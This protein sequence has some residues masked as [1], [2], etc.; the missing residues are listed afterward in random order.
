M[1]P[2]PAIDGATAETVAQGL[3]IGFIYLSALAVAAAALVTAAL[4]IS[5]Y[6]GLALDGVEHLAPRGRGARFGS[7]LIASLGGT[8]LLCLLAAAAAYPLTTREVP[9]TLRTVTAKVVDRDLDPTHEAIAEDTALAPAVTTGGVGFAVVPVERTV[10]VPSRTSVLLA[11]DG[12]QAWMPVD[13]RLYRK[14]GIG[15]AVRL[16][17]RE[18]RLMA[19]IG[20]RASQHVAG[21]ITGLV[22]TP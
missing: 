6:A 1:V 14:L 18:Q 17:L 2:V 7:R 10:H 5:A 19:L 4:P 15:I 16:E 21:P 12:G 3:S 20:V 8:A 22:S 13:G 9:G 11:W